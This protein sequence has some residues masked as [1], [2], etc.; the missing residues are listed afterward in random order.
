ML[1]LRVYTRELARS[2]RQVGTPTQPIDTIKQTPFTPHSK[3]GLMSV[4]LVNF[5]ARCIGS[6]TLLAICLWLSA[7]CDL[8]GQGQ[9][10]GSIAQL[11]ELR[12]AQQPRTRGVFIVA[13]GLNQRPD[14]MRDIVQLLRELGFHTYRLSLRGHEKFEN[15]TFPASSWIDDINNACSDV[16]TRFPRIPVYILGY[17]LGGLVATHAI[18]AQTA[19]Q[20]ASMILIA[21]ALSLRN[22][23]QTGYS[24]SVFPQLTISVPNVA[25]SLY[26]RFDQTPLFWYQNLFS[27]YSKTRT[28]RSPARL[29]SIP[30]LIFAN[31]RDELVSLAGLRNWISAND[32]EPAWA[33]DVVRPQPRNPFT[34]EHVMI[35]PRS[36]GEGE[37]QHLSNSVRAFLHTPHRQEGGLQITKR[38]PQE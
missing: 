4:Y 29:R 7:C 2:Y 16:T 35:D 5:C 12:L 26:R 30:T 34:P 10:Q 38:A 22:F 18:D 24:L 17:S 15:E 21:P 37:W 6:A 27:L 28:L 9:R 13:H 3:I 31:P 14:T 23:V 25:P 19:C 1:N 8:F 11:S 33:I 36:L 20:P 32:L